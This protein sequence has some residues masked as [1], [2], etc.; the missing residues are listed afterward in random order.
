MTILTDT[1]T[2][3]QHDTKLTSRAIDNTIAKIS[4][5]AKL[6]KAYPEDC[7]DLLNKVANLSNEDYKALSDFQG[8]KKCQI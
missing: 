6:P 7:L 8:R 3:Y 2:H 4:L 5:T 1:K